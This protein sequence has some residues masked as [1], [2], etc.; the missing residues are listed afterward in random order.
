MGTVQH[1]AL[2]LHKLQQ[3]EQTNQPNQTSTLPSA[4]SQPP[5]SDGPSTQP[6]PPTSATTTPV[7][8]PSWGE[9]FTASPSIPPIRSLN[10][11]HPALG[12]SLCPLAARIS[13]P[14]ASTLRPSLSLSFPPH[15]GANRTTTTIIIRSTSN[16]KRGKLIQIH[17]IAHPPAAPMSADSPDDRPAAAQ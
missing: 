3:V 8:Q 12:R 14:P 11:L 5:G 9:P 1:F 7:L 10:P 6:A 13:R 16:T 17:L 4:S 2:F 15:P